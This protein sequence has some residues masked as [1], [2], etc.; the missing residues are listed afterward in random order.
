[1]RVH[2]LHTPEEVAR[3]LQ[4]RVTGT[5]CADSRK[6]APGDGFIAWPGAATDGRKYVNAAL[7]AGAAAC[8]VEHAGAQAYGFSDDRV[9]TYEGLKA[10]TGPIAAAYFGVPSEHLQVTA[11]TGTNGKT[12]TAW[13]LAQALDR[14]GCKCGVVGTL[15]VGQPGAMV[16]NGLTTP[17]PV[18]LQQQLRRFVDESFV[19]CALE[20]SSIGLKELRLEGTR[21][22]L[23]VFTNFTQDHLDY[24]PS[25]ADY[26]QAKKMLFSWPGLQVAIINIDDAKGFELRDALVDSPLDVWTFSCTGLA[27][28]QAQFICH[29]AHN[30]S[31]D[32]VEGTERHR[33]STRMVGLYNVSN[34]LGVM[35]SLRAMDI[36]LADAV[37]ACADLLPV[38][39]RTETLTVPGKPLVVIDYA[40]T[41]DALEKVL[42]AIKPVAVSRGGR[43]W[44]VFGCG[45]DRDATKRPLMAAIAEK[46]A[47]QLVVTSDNPRTEDPH[48][49]ID[50]ML[51]GL[52]HADAALVQVDRAAAIDDALRLAQAGDV[53]LVAG[54][55]HEN[56]QDIKGVKFAFSDRD[57]AQSALDT[58]VAVSSHQVSA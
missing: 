34:L 8:L 28:L 30:L 50:Q 22:R 41:P 51:F 19:A 29:G 25:M 36:S 45:G 54:K 23:A 11:I 27:R 58:L 26:W 49:I 7:V 14:L 47:D 39:G 3:W 57:Q 1:M 4:E 56:Y 44:C 10:A 48:V 18:L 24:H 32:V 37:N 31:F 17:D 53:V 46:N 12:S 43:L 5:L 42:M 13:W 16:F 33:I 6:L 15:G 9:A 20:A 21:I 55:G 38:P 2:Q 52:T 35:A 40:H